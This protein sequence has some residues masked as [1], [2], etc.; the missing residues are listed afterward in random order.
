MGSELTL[1]AALTA[2]LIGSSHCVAMCGGIAAALG[3]SSRQ[4][5]ASSTR[6]TVYIVLFSLGRVSG[7][8]LIGAIAGL[9]GQGVAAS[10][11][12]AFW[13]LVTRLATGLL[14]VAIGLQVA[15]H[16]RLL[17]VVERSGSWLWARLAPLARRFLPPRRPDHAFALGFL[18]GWLPCGLVYSMVLMA[19]L[20]GDW[21][22]SALLMASFGVGTIPAMA[23]MGLASSR[24]RPRGRAATL[25]RLAGLALI[26]FG[27][28]TAAQPIASALQGGHQHAG[29]TMTDGN[30][31]TSID[32][33]L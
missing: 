23:A 28:W 2:G 30:A 10:F 8:A 22:L 9:A 13:A 18:W 19:M 6:S 3:M 24:F 7:Y 20:V 15:F 11:D 1:L 21:R 17:A 31:E 12:I 25:K 29:H 33:G 5:G 14:L 4:S 26:I 16:L 27:I 32:G